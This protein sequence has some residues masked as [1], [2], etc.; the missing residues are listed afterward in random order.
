MSSFEFIIDGPPI[1][2]YSRH[3]EGLHNWKDLVRAE[4]ERLW[5]QGNLPS[6]G[7]LHITITYYYENSPVDTSG[8]VKPI[9]DA[10]IGLVYNDNS[11]IDELTLSRQDLYGSFRIPD[12]S[13][14]LAEGFGRSHEFLHVKIDGLPAFREL[15]KEVEPEAILEDGLQTEPPQ[16]ELAQMASDSLR[17]HQPQNIESSSQAM[18]DQQAYASS[19]DIEAAGGAPE[20][21]APDRLADGDQPESSQTPVDENASEDGSLEGVPLIEENEAAETHIEVDSSTE[22]EESESLFDRE[23]AIQDVEDQGTSDNSLRT[24]EQPADL[25]DHASTSEDQES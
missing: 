10:L 19:Q 7:T 15:V 18:D 12:F 1:T 3:R 21:V 9:T 11:Q 2:Q 8:I 13:P 17:E 23:P 4:A 25:E 6:N 20:M 14:V 22:V 24:A 5:P 16:P